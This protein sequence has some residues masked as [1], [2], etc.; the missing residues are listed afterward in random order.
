MDPDETLRLL[1]DAAVAGDAAAFDVHQFDLW[2]WLN[3]DGFPPDDP[4]EVKPDA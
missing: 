2:N 1:I 4:R 3:D